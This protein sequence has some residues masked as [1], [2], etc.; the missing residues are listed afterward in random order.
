MICTARALQ[1][2]NELFHL[3]ADKSN[4]NSRMMLHEAGESAGLQ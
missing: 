4:S 2:N 3:E 1:E